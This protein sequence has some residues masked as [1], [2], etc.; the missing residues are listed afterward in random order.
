MV[1]NMTE[2]KPF[3]LILKFAIPMLIGNL[4]QQAYNLVDMVIVGKFVGPDALA[5]VGTTGTVLFLMISLI[6][7]L[8]NGAGIVIAQYYGSKN[9]VSLRKTVV[10]LGYLILGLSI[11]VSIIGSLGSLYFLKL[12]QVPDDII[13]ESNA[14]LKI[15]FQFII[16][17]T[18]YNG[19]S[20]VLRSLGDSRTPLYALIAATITNIMLD[21]IFV[22]YFHMGV[23]GVAYAT[24]ISQLVS[25]IIC[26]HQIVKQRNELHLT[27][28][29]LKP[30]KYI[31]ALIFK[32]GIP[33]A[34]QSS[35]IALGSM[36][37]QGLVNSFGTVVMSAYAAV[38][39]IDSVA[40]QVIVSLG[41]SLSV[42]SGQ[43]IGSGNMKRIK[44]GLHQT[45]IM[46]TTAS[47]SIAVIVLIFKRSLLS[48]FL[49]PTTA[50]DSI[51]IGITYLTIIGIAYIIAGVMNSYLNVIR[52][53]GDVNTSMVSG[54]AELSARIVFS[55]LLV[56]PLGTTGIWLATPISWGCGCIIPIVR[57]Y[58]GKWKS[59]KIA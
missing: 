26:I 9:F 21:I 12:L 4:F 31:F 1:K 38:L 40:I 6:N 18:I 58:S 27:E 28:L 30:D 19:A 41:T 22:A 49:D 17:L 24:V 43:N 10:S 54:L 51:E 11:L 53:A 35:L 57:Y 52:G 39:K 13:M 25:A 48:F 37:V 44:Q 2:G 50:K 47:V 15:C 16:G 46:M 29:E 7:G 42:Y 8:C 45:L 55:Y 33:A 5:A 14:Y 23:K 56:K 36:S 34:L 3:Q 20:A 32:T 59:K